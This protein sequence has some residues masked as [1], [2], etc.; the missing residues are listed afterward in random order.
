MS[1][2]TSTRRFAGTSRQLAAE[3]KSL[4]PGDYLLIEGTPGLRLVAGQSART[5]IHRYRASDGRIVQ[6]RIGAWPAI[7][8]AEAVATVEANN[9]ARA[10]GD[11]PAQAR[12]LE[13]QQ[14]ERDEAAVRAKAYTVAVM[15]EDYL[16]EHVEQA[17]TAKSANECR[18]LLVKNV[19]PEFGSRAAMDVRRSDVVT[20]LAKLALRTSSSARVV[21][22][23]MRAAFDH[24]VSHGRVDECVVNAWDAA[25]RDRSLR[26]RLKA[27]RRSRY[28]SDAEIVTLLRWVP[29]SGMSRTVRDALELTLRLGMRSGEVVAARWADIDLE[30]ATWTLADTKT[31]SPRT[32]RLPPQAVEILRN[33]L[34]LHDEFV[35]P[36][37]DGKKAI[38]QPALSW[39]LKEHRPGC[40][41]AS[42]S[43][44]DLRRSC[45]TGLARLDC[46]HEVGEA[47]LGH[48]RGG[49]A[50]VYDLHRYEAQV[51]LWL[52]RWNNHIDALTGHAVVP[53]NRPERAVAG[54]SS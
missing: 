51:G 49:I 52:Q 44:H 9:R 7:T 19:L 29:I 33:R 34:P 18:R 38:R 27:G 35:F 53:M 50:G 40:S 30:A 46:P 28:L 37:P 4:A 13:R 20:F 47:A 12:D 39:S 16:V 8:Q 43:A 42:F 2:K 24:A 45:R 26:K 10:R 25:G 17:R 22:T 1:G 6:V 15:I 14:R 21:R 5:W 36:R 11:D 41:L 3:A 32:V 31:D 48:T 54:R 23:E